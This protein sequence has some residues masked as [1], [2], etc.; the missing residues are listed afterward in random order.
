MIDHLQAGERE[1]P[2]VAQSKAKSLK[3]REDD[4]VAFSVQPKGQEPKEA[5]G[6]SLKS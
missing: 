4:S 2:V 5:V 1:N 6:V 3:T